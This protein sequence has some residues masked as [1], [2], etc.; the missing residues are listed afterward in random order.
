MVVAVALPESARRDLSAVISRLRRDHSVIR[1]EVKLPKVGE[2]GYLRFL[3]SLQDI[4]LVLFATATDSGLNTPELIQVHKT[5]Q[6]SDIRANIP[7]MRYDGGKLGLKLL[8]D[9]LEALPNQLYVQ[10]LCQVNLLYDVI[11]RGINYFAQRHP[12]TL[13][14]FR[15]RIDQKNSTKTMFEEAFEKIAPAL[16]QTRSIREPFMAIRG[17]D[18]SHI[19]AY[20]F[21]E[22]EAPDYLQTEY[23]LPPFEGFNIQKL[24]RGN[25]Q[26]IDSNSSDGIQ[27]ADL[28]ASGLRRVLKRSFDDPESIACAL[29]RLTVQ[30]FQKNQPINFIS[31]SAEQEINQ[32][33]LDIVRLIAD[34]SRPLLR[35]R[36]QP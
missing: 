30:N 2:T 6:V 1:G 20:E 34:S 8:A 28:L 26:F 32:E 4:G 15:W 31:L 3:E 11:N 27:V 17:F 7:R 12:A 36:R 29:G 5:A 19:G 18:Y 13:R 25:L 9:Q 33:A 24:I 16:L 14:E 10:L 35:K 23:G 22:G 21:A